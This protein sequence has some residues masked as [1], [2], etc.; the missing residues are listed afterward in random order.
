MA[1]GLFLFPRDSGGTWQLV[2]GL[3]RRLPDQ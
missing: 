1:E 3:S 2:C